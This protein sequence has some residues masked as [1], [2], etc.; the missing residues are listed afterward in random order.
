M[1][2]ESE[3]TAQITAQFRKAGYLAFKT[4]DGFTT[5]IPDLVVVNH[6]TTWFEMK[7]LR[8]KQT[9]YRRVR[10]SEVQFQVMRAIFNKCGRAYYVIRYHDGTNRVMIPTTFDRPI[11]DK[12]ILERCKPLTLDELVDYAEL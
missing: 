3:W 8:E 12:E 6:Q 10:E 1:L 7:L 2:T 4:A 11:G 5:A 9:M